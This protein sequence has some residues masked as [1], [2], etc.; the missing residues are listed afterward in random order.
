MQ[1]AGWGPFRNAEWGAA[2]QSGE[3]MTALDLVS[4][5]YAIYG[6][7][8]LGGGN[9]YRHPRRGWANA[10]TPFEPWHQN[11]EYQ[12]GNLWF[13]ASAKASMTG[14]APCLAAKAMT[15][16]K[17]GPSKGLEYDTEK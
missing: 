4:L 6:S 2:G 16:L 1:S 14:V 13:E 7:T 11:L 15:R 12:V 17:D 10:S 8:S 5:R 3:I 9:A